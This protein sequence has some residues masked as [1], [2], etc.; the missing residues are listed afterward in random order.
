MCIK[1]KTSV[2]C[3][4][5]PIAWLRV[6][7]ALSGTAVTSLF[8]F[9]PILLWRHVPVCW[10]PITTKFKTLWRQNPK[11]KDEFVVPKHRR[12][13]WIENSFHFISFLPQYCYHAHVSSCVLC[14]C[15]YHAAYELSL[16]SDYSFIPSPSGQLTCP[17]PQPSFCACNLIFWSPVATART[18]CTLCTV[19]SVSSTHSDYYSTQHWLLV[20]RAHTHCLLCRTKLILKFNPLS[21]RLKRFR[22]VPQTQCKVAFPVPRVLIYKVAVSLVCTFECFAAECTGP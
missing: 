1:I 12:D 5:I 15:G 22:S 2:A 19:P 18:L 13:V 9:P 11:T 17:V 6:L 3:Y 14:I 16:W 8:L 10:P 21:F 7:A 20:C 4:T